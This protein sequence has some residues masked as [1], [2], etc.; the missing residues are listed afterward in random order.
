M[1][2]RYI[3]QV[4]HNEIAHPGAECP[5]CKSRSLIAEGASPWIISIVFA[6]MIVGFG[7]TAIYTGNFR[8]DREGRG[9]YHF[10]RAKNLLDEELPDRA[11]NHYRDALLHSREDSAYRLGLAEALFKTAR[12][13][14]TRTHLLE[15][16]LEDP[17]SGIVN[18]HLAQLAEREG[19]LDEAATY[20]RTS[21]HGRWEDS[22]DASADEIRRRIRFRLAD[23]LEESN[24]AHELTA[25]LVELLKGDPASSQLRHRLASQLLD[26]GAYNRASE[27]YRTLIGQDSE[28]R[29]ALLGRARAE[30]HLRNY[31]TSRTHYLRANALTSD[32]ETSARIEL[33]NRIIALDPTRRGISL[34]ERFRRSKALIERSLAIVETC[35][36]PEGSAFVGPLPPVPPDLVPVVR[37]AEAMLAKRSRVAHDE[38][39]EENIQIAEEILAHIDSHCERVEPVDESFA[40][41]MAKL[42]Q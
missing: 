40:L 41:I 7:L 32:E 42:A 37:G 25:E 1:S 35:R 17:T 24:R 23:V 11:I 12:Y 5:Y 13:A 27:E 21:V 6:V 28:D 20:Y 22:E 26:S 3:C 36:A 2:T 15:L 30:F 39:V 33:C 8:A 16:L 31:I 10:T 34:Q 19:R 14:E 18:Y 9:Q 29:S 38:T 4:C